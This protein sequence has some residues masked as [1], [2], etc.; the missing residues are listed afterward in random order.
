MD[1]LYYHCLD[2]AIGRILVA[3]GPQGI[4]RICLPA[5]FSADWVS[6]FDRHFSSRPHSLD[7]PLLSNA[8]RQLE[9]Y[10]SARRRVFDLLLDLRGTPFQRRVWQQ[11]VKIPYGSTVSYAEVSRRIH[12]P[13]AWRAVGSAVGQ[14]PVPI[15]VP[16]H[17]VIG[18]DG[19][20][21]GFGGGLSLKGHL[22]ELE[23]LRIPFDR[24]SE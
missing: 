22:L 15:I 24:S 6:W 5:T 11:L 16:C 3:G 14:N 13:R 21:G 19:S 7:Y 20:L 9:E 18:S 10:F 17:R 23:G 2:T 1:R 4:C 8:A 12:S